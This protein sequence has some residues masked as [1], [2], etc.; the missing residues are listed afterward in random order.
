MFNIN[1]HTPAL[2]TDD[3]IISHSQLRTLEK[4]LLDFIDSCSLVLLVSKNSVGS[5]IGYTSF[6]NNGNPILMTDEWGEEELNILII[7]YEP[8]YIWSSKDYP[9]AN[10]KYV[11]I[12]S[13]FDFVLYERLENVSSLNTEVALLLPTSGS[14]GNK[15]FVRITK[16]NLLSNTKSIVS[17]LNL[18][19]SD[20]SITSL[21]MS[22]TYGLSVIN[23][24]LSVGGSIYVTNHPILSKDFWGLLRDSGVTNLNGVPYSYDIFIRLGL[25]QSSFPNLRFLTQAGGPLSAKKHQLIAEYCRESKLDFFV[26]YGQT[27]ATSRMSFLPPEYAITKVGSIGIPI[28]DGSFTIDKSTSELLYQGPNVSIGY[29]TCKDDLGKPDLFKGVL[30]TG[31]TA[32]VDLDG[33][34]YIT[35]RLSRF[36]KITGKRVSLDD[37]Q[38][39]LS[40][41][42]PH[43]SFAV[44]GEDDKITVF[45]ECKTES[46]ESCSLSSL[47]VNY[48]CE[49]IQV[50]KRMISVAVIPNIPRNSSGKILF[51]NLKDEKLVD[52]Q[53]A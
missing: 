46:T 45:I 12:Y 34:Y 2:V 9:L 11:K 28:P 35:G 42:Y 44:V 30:H 21:P 33:F 51:K 48:L 19:A 29:A 38:A 15:K 6:I 23:T 31:D 50:N 41:K 43:Y 27:E 36:I 16:N 39:M 37:I 52:T 18:Q 8:Q 32:K 13:A 10:N 47:I 14:T 4:E 1:T 20:R 7:E 3:S 25:L 26:M 5:I 49:R 17:Y 40:D 24:H 53:K 22:Y